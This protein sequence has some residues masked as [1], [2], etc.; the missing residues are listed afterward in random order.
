[1]QGCSQSLFHKLISL[2]DCHWGFPAEMVG[3]AGVNS[4]RH[5]VGT[6]VSQNASHIVLNTSEYEGRRFCLFIAMHTLPA[7]VRA[8]LRLFGLLNVDGRT[9]APAWRNLELSN[10]PQAVY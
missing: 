2:A 4:H 5:V 3:R 6:P 10:W 1:M 7:E 8:E 9:E